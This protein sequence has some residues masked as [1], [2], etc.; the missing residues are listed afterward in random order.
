M[1]TTTFVNMIQRVKDSVSKVPEK[2]GVMLPSELKPSF[3]TLS[4][5]L[6]MSLGKVHARLSCCK[7][8]SWSY[9]ENPLQKEMTFAKFRNILSPY[10]WRL[11]TQVTP[12]AVQ[13][14]THKESTPFFQTKSL[15][16]L[17]QE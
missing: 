11:H 10:H 1:D 7:K 13:E 17:L 4:M 6:V 5:Q 12:L 15:N 3:S 8:A 16:W 2:L 14:D 9:Y